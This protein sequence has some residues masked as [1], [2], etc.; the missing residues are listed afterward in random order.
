MESTMLTA[1][2]VIHTEQLLTLYRTQSGKSNA[3]AEDL[4]HLLSF[5]SPDREALLHNACQLT[6]TRNNQIVTPHY[7][8]L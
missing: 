4:F 7:Q 3:S 5:P 8:P 1:P 6:Y 2:V